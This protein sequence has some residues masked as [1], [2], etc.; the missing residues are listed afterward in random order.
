MLQIRALVL[1]QSRALHIGQH[2]AAQADEDP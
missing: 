1:A 2:S